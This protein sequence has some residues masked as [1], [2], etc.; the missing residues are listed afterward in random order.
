MVVQPAGTQSHTILFSSA[1]GIIP[2]PNLVPHFAYWTWV[3]YL[4]YCT[5]WHFPL[6]SDWWI[7]LEVS[8]TFLFSSLCPQTSVTLFVESDC[9][10]KYELNCWSRFVWATSPKGLNFQK[11]PELHNI[12]GAWS[13][14]LSQLQVK[15]A[16]QFW[17]Q[18]LIPCLGPRFFLS[19][20]CFNDCA[21]IL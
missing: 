9:D 14:S 12:F 4:I 19:H 8:V 17:R 15:C 7:S 16:S 1:S 21:F 11:A 20:L 3:P 13:S 10:R 2:G 18:G 5:H 6:W